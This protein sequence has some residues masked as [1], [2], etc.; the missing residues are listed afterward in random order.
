M[1][2]LAAARPWLMRGL[3]LAFFAVLLYVALRYAR[4]IAWHEVGQAL[5]ATP[6]HVLASAIVLAAASHATY[7]SFDLL[8]RRYTGHPLRVGQVMCVTFVSYAF[9]LNLGSVVGGIA[10]RLRLYSRLGLSYLTTTRVFTLSIV[11]NWFG[12]CLLAGVTLAFAPPQVPAERNLGS[13]G[14]RALGGALLTVAAAYL[15][16]CLGSRRRRFRVRRFAFRLPSM[17]MVGAQ[18]ALSCSNWLTM[19]AL[20]FVLFQGR[21]PYH[22]V[23]GVLLVAAFAGILIHVPAGLGV[24]EAVFVTLLSHR[25]PQAQLLAVL[26]TYRAVYYLAPLALAAVL[27]LM[28]EFRSR[29]AS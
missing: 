13:P 20:L 1:T 10:V 16:L 12:Y 3:T 28:M 2:A 8:G 15:G 23:L 14:L 19:G 24:L 27:Y 7:S 21:L 11:T 29:P 5:A 25:L 26:L 6:L 18:L 22:E 9:N 4:T 17:P